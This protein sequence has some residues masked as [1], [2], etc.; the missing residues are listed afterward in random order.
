MRGLARGR[1]G[2]EGEKGEC[3]GL[4]TRMRS[5]SLPMLCRS[6]TGRYP[7]PFSCLFRLPINPPSSP[8]RHPSQ[9][10]F[11]ARLIPSL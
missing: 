6:A 3:C 7:N 9:R 2:G 4:G 11:V 10:L 8:P 1:D 5:H